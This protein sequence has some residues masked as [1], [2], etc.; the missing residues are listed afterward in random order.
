MLYGFSSTFGVFGGEHELFRI[1]PFE[2]NGQRFGKQRLV[3]LV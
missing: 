1:I 2:R 3:L